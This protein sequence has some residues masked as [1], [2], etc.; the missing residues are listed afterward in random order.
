MKS[1]SMSAEIGSCSKKGVRTAA[2]S[3]A[4]WLTWAG[5]VMGQGGPQPPF[6]PAPVLQ[7]GLH[8]FAVQNLDTGEVE[9]RGIA[10]SNGIAFS[11]LIIAP[12]TP[13][14]IW[15]LQARTLA[16]ADASVIT[17]GNGR[18]FHVPPLQFRNSESRDLDGDGLHDEGEFILGTI[19]DPENPNSRD[20]DRDGISDGAEVLQGTDPLDGLA[21]RTGLIGTADTPGTA[22]DVCAFNDNVVVADAEAGITVFNVFNGMQP[23]AIAQVDTPGR[24]QAIA[25]TDRLL[26]VADGSA[27]LAI[28][29]ASDPPAAR[30]TRQVAVGGSAQTVVSAGGIAY[31]G[32]DSGR[33]VAVDLASATVLEQLLTGGAVHDIG[34]EGDTLF[35]LLANELQA[36][37]LL[38]ELE[39]LGRATPSSFQAEGITQRKR[40]FVGGGIAYVTSFPGYDT[41]DVANPA[42]MRPIGRATDRGPN[43]FK[44]I[45]VNGSGLGVAAVGVNPREDGTHDVFLYDVS[46]PATTTDFITQFATPGTTRAVA[47]FNGIAYAADSAAGLQ[48][49][50]YLA[51]DV[52]GVPPAITLRSNFALG[53]AEEGQV[54]RLTADVRDDVQVRNVEFYID[55]VKVATDGNFPFEHRFVTPL[56]SE[57]TSFT[58]QGRASDTG[59]NATFTDPIIFEIVP[60]ARPPRVTRTSPG[61]NAI[62]PAISVIA[63]FFNEPI[64]PDTLTAST[65]A[66]FSAGP[67]GER[68]T[69]DD[70]AVPG[71]VEFRDSVR[72]A[73]RTMAGP[74]AP[75]RYRARLGTGVADLAGNGLVEAFEWD[76]TVFD[77]AADRDSDGVPDDL[78]S[79]LGLD[80][81]N[82]DSD[83]NG[84][85][86][87]EEDFDNDGL[88]NS[89]EVRFGTDPT[90]PDSDGDGILDGDEDDDLDGLPDGEE[91]RRGTDPR[92]PDT[93]GDGWPDGA[94]VD[95]GSN[96]ASRLSVPRT[97]GVA[98]PPVSVVVQ[99][100]GDVMGL[101]PN[102]TVASPPVSVVV[103]EIG[104]VMGLAPSTTVAAPPVSVVVQEIGDVMGLAP[105]TTVAQPPVSVVVQQIGDVMGLAPNTTVAQPP[106]SVRIEGQ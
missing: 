40:V 42:A 48:V 100:V 85:P 47:I 53:A 37:S 68:G 96:P 54:M 23:L 25:C 75:S 22:V 6:Q 12:D 76:F 98:A 16:V 79:A 58:V 94:E 73:F 39:L 55:G 83:G 51:Y 92:S 7:E 33:L 5:A 87:G 70:V 17:P 106:V 46:D 44:Q 97:T 4:L 101:V 52:N 104:D 38:P 26:A 14:R 61:P 21:V 34:I 10:G 103:Q 93:D 28:V 2:C 29:D 88:S 30:I 78:E 31:A 32:T 1:R 57:K 67:D 36:Y 69:G 105:S 20:S 59:G 24:A 90:N 8:Y 27:G 18:T 77:V 84:I 71:T 60:D 41:F 3:A 80:P 13:Y 91:A 9:Q 35:V 66:L 99:A 74:L 82:P 63:A 89:G 86:D 95:A 43:S 64:D 19:N 102:T 62:V 50:N 65:F 45:V 49:V 11:R 72:G 56:R 15:I 81:D